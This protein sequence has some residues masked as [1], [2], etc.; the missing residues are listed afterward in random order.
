[1][2]GIDYLGSMKPELCGT[3]SDII[4]LVDLLLLIWFHLLVFLTCDYNK[5]YSHFSFQYENVGF[6]L[7]ITFPPSQFFSA[8]LLIQFAFSCVIGQESLS[9]AGDDNGSNGDNFMLV[10][11]WL[12][13]KNRHI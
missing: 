10:S 9:T 6:N 7:T 8:G 5:N 4:S 12:A 2:S 1:M 13:M 11:V 3:K